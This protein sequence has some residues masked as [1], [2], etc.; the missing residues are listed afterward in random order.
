MNDPDSLIARMQAQANA[1][2]ER[3][4]QRAIFLRCYAMMTAN[5][6]QALEQQRFE[7]CDWVGRLL[8]RFADY[9]FEALACFDCGEAVPP[10]WQDVH[11]TTATRE[12]HV[13]QHL[14]LGVNAHINYDLVLTL[15]EMLRPEWEQLAEAQ[16]QCRYR[17]HRRV[18]TIIAET[19]DRVQDEVVEKYSPFMKLVD[20]AFGRLDEQLLVGLITRWRET[21]WENAQ[22]LLRTDQEKLRELHRREVEAEVLRTARW[23]RVG[24]PLR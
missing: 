9:Y 5:M 10:V 19:I 18:N 3:R 6:L 16:R 11:E 2:E 1:W 17:D 13:L 20:A 22:L 7:D 8:H 4:D 12:L 15:D 21:V 23:L 24:L 14:L